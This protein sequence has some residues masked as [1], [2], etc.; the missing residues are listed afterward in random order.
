MNKL[1]SAMD[2]LNFQQIGGKFLNTAIKLSRSTYLF[3]TQMLNCRDTGHVHCNDIRA[4]KAGIL[5]GMHLPS[6]CL[7]FKTE[8]SCHY[9]IMNQSPVIMTG[10]CCWSNVFTL[11]TVMFRKATIL[12]EV[13][14]AS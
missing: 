11:I 3:G 10:F 8:S 6:I 13:C 14:R 7:F 9:V 4:T 12:A 5:I 1:E 2:M